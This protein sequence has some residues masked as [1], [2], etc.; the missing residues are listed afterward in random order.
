MAATVSRKKALAVA[1]TLP[2]RGHAYE[3]RHGGETIN[4]ALFLRLGV[5]R[6]MV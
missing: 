4:M 3:Y 6:G 2:R 1:M 5:R